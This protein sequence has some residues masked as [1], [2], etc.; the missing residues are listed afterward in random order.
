MDPNA[1]LREIDAFLARHETGDEV[2]IHC[3]NLFDWIQRG[4]FEPEWSRYPLGTS[5]YRC[6][7]IHHRQGER[8]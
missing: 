6:R 8:V 2:D 7:E 5:Y 1:T 3:Q 4:G